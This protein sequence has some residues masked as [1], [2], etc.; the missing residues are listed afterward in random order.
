MQAVAPP[1]NSR[2]DRL[3]AWQ[4]AATLAFTVVVI[5]TVLL[6]FA[7]AGVRIRHKIRHGDF[8][9][10]EETYTLDPA[11]GLR[12]PI[13]G[14][15]FGPISINS[16]GFRSPEITED[17][18]VGRLRIAFLGGSTTYCGEVSSN[19]MTW[20]HLVWKAR[21]K[22]WPELDLD[23]INAGVPGY[24]TRALLPALEKRVARFEPDII[25]IYEAVNDLRGNSYGL[26]HDQGVVASRPQVDGF[27]WL[28]RHSL[29]AL[30][31]RKNL[32]IVRLQRLATDSSG[33]VTL[34][35]ARL[36]AEFREDY[37]NLVTASAKVAKIVVTAT[38]APRLR[39][40]QSPEERKEA[41]VTDL[42]YTPYMTIDDL[43]ATY[44]HYN[45]VIREVAGAHHT[46]LVSEEESIPADAKHYTDSVH[47]T[48]AGSLA[49]AHRV[50]EA[51]I[52]SATVQALVEAKVA[53]LERAN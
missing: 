44:A 36:D 42:Y 39:A 38:F 20:P 21:H 14:G 53:Q 40:E 25:V 26:A 16:S 31:V 12:I 17:K 33:K 45:Q 3:P 46:L 47:Y 52:S 4:R 24:S 6:L 30:L 41:A 43:L 29:L 51:L 27:D 8:W 34:D 7:E 11:S 28:N 23:Y 49:M 19:E 37:T 1:P 48:D 22:H 13:S 35:T 10:I 2:F 18:P 15:R 50:I 9:G 5:C 32:E